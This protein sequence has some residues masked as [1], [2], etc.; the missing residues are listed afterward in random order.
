M[1]KI[2]IDKDK[3]EEMRKI[4]VNYFYDER[5]ED[6]GDLASQLILEFFLEELGPYI[7]N[8]G[9]EDAYAY[10]KDITEDILALQIYRRD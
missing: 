7:Y 10:T 1:N 5:D 9:V 6:L 3:K 4:I 2:K 8:Q